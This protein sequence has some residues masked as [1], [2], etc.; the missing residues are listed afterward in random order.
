MRKI[1]L[2]ILFCVA[3]L[4]AVAG[5]KVVSGNFGVLL[6]VGNL[7]V[8]VNWNDAKYGYGG[9]LDHFLLKAP[10]LQDWERLSLM[11]FYTEVNKE[12]TEFGAHVYPMSPDDEYQYYLVI[13]VQKISTDG[14]ISGFI[15]LNAADRSQPVAVAQF[16]SDEADDDDKIAFKDQFESI[17]ESFGYLLFKQLRKEYKQRKR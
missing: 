6:G 3:M 8:M 10:R 5:S 14:N 2:G 17:G 13:S 11:P 4:P 9:N 16:S 15:F 7:P 12:I 1:I